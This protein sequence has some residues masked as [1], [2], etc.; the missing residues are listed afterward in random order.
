MTQVDVVY[1]IPTQF[2]TVTFYNLKTQKTNYTLDQILISC[3]FDDEPCSS[4]DFEITDDKS[5]KFNSGINRTKQ[6]IEFKTSSIPGKESGL[7]IEVFIGLPD[8]DQPYGD[9]NR[10][11]GLHVVVHNNTVDPRFHDGIDISPGFAT[12]LIVSRS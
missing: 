4:D 10:Y 11:D 9:Y 2:P 6:P 8:D 1:E 3:S 12:N 5:Y 7:Q